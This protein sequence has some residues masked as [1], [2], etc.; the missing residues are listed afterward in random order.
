[1]TQSE[2]GDASGGTSGDGDAPGADIECSA[3]PSLAFTKLEGAVLNVAMGGVSDI[4]QNCAGGVDPDAVDC[5]L[6]SY[7]QGVCV[8]DFDGDGRSDLFLTD[9]YGPAHLLRAV[10]DGSFEDAGAAW[11]LNHETPSSGS[12][13]FDADKDGDLDLYVLT[14]LGDRQYF[15]RNEGDHF[16]EAAMSAGLD[17]SEAHALGS[18][19][20]AV[21][22]VNLDGWPDLFVTG[23]RVHAPDVEGSTNRL[24]VN[25]GESAPGQFDEISE[26]AGLDQAGFAT[27]EFTN[28][29]IYGG[30]SP[31]FVDLDGDD[32]PELIEVADY[33]GEQVFRNSGD[34]GFEDLTEA[35]GSG[36]TSNGMGLAVA[37]LDGDADM[38]WFVTSIAP[39]SGSCQNLPNQN[40]GNRLYLNDVAGPTAGVRVADDEAAIACSGWGWGAAIADVDNDG[41]PDIAATNGWFEASVPGNYYEQDVDRIWINPG[42]PTDGMP[43]CAEELGFDDAGQGR[44]LVTLDLDGDGDLDFI[45]SRAGDRPLVYRNDGGVESGASLRVRLRGR[46]TMTSGRGARIAVQISEG[47][48][49]QVGEVGQASH[50]L[51]HSELVAHF[52]V[53]IGV[54]SLH[55]VRVCWPVSRRMQKVADIAPGLLVLDEDDADVVVDGPCALAVIDPVY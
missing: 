55:E 2:E 25:R 8:G 54:E 24:F 6:E 12:A 18:S 29:A 45:E 22:D 49:W 5:F 34:L 10:G 14:Y 20:V 19:G 43:L 48:P 44:A 4:D 46:D 1:M 41:H 51:G 37:D 7:A 36:R 9:S 28:L 47:G 33:G 40:L 23:W 15:Y 52:G 21:G 3:P 30:F 50:L 42:Q 31:A 16:V 26:S 13:W 11:Q 17:M 38:D 53:G 35:W 39:V 27:Y 32:Y